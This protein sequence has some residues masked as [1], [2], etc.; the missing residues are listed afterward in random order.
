MSVRTAARA[1]AVETLGRAFKAANA[2]LRRLRGRETHRPG[3]LSHAQYSLLFALC[4]DVPRSLRELAESADISPGTAAEML[5]ALD[6]AGLVK[7]ERSTADR[8]VVLT[9]L[10]DRGRAVVYARRARYEPRW[11]ATLQP[12]TEEELRTAA[13]VLD[14]VRLMFDELAEEDPNPS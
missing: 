5:D 13:V 14:Q 7:R 4:D 6:G 1:D 10:T 12:F 11:R 9:S 3:A 8:R 2:A